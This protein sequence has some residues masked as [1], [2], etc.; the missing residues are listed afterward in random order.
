MNIHLAQLGCR[1]NFSEN[2]QL[3]RALQGAGH[4][5]VN[6][7]EQAHVA[8]VNTCAVTVAASGKSR[9]L[10]RHLHRSHPDLRI[11]A[12]GCLDP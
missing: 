1:L 4:V 5:V 7:P 6:R 10:I 11:V 9:R 3:A 8:V 2:H 12:T